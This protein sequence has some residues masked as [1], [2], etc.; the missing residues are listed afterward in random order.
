MRWIS[1]VPNGVD[2]G[3]PHHTEISGLNEYN[4]YSHLLKRINVGALAYAGNPENYSNHE[5][6]KKCRAIGIPLLGG[7]GIYHH[8][9]QL[10]AL[11]EQLS[12]CRQQN[13]ELTEAFRENI[14]IKEE[15]MKLLELLRCDHAEEY[16]KSSKAVFHEIMDKAKAD[17]ESLNKQQ[18]ELEARHLLREFEL[19][20][21]LKKSH[22][23]TTRLLVERLTELNKQQA[24]RQRQVEEHQKKADSLHA[25]GDEIARLGGP[26]VPL[27][28]KNSTRLAEMMQEYN[29]MQCESPPMCSIDIVDRDGVVPPTEMCLRP[30][31]EPF[32]TAT[33]AVRD[34]EYKRNM[35][36]AKRM[37]STMWEVF[38]V[39]RPDVLPSRQEE[40]VDNEVFFRKLPDIAVRDKG[41]VKQLL[42]KNHFN[43]PEMRLFLEKLARNIAFYM[44]AEHRKFS[45]ITGPRESLDLQ[46]DANVSQS[47]D[48]MLSPVGTHRK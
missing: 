13:S 14:R 36:L 11:R 23:A 48:K 29:A 39:R 18:D 22:E 12:S 8:T 44:K 45:D 28:L 46:T 27:N 16:I 25:M 3:R 24:E 17:I 5:A 4:I 40:L 2:R 1:T 6:D 26:Y 32:Q 42:Y 30:D 35:E 15:A 37:L 20:D 10:D 31:E 34:H 43:D 38:G 21:E 19:V 33:R 41:K 47:I 7:A 9:V